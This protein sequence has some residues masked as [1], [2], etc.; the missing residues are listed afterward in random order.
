MIFVLIGKIFSLYDLSCL[1]TPV[2]YISKIL[3]AW[4]LSALLVTA[5]LFLLR[6]GDDVLS[7]FNDDFRPIDARAIDFF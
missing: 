2:K 4:I 5:M 3:V 6:A 1:S 7:R